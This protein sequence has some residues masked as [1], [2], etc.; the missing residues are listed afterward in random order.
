M[1]KK[2][3]SRNQRGSK[4][5]NG[6]RRK[7][8]CAEPKAKATTTTWHG[9][10]GWAG[11]VGQGDVVDGHQWCW[12]RVTGLG[13]LGDGR[14]RRRSDDCT[15]LTGRW[16]ASSERGRT[17]LRERGLTSWRETGVW[18]MAYMALGNTARNAPNF[19]SSPQVDDVGSTHWCSFPTAFR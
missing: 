9:I 7:R 10:C 15:Q 13:N 5:R 8:M 1:A 4:A 14:P 12:V 18:K 6:T 16:L 2:G 17:K 11:Y 3:N 19:P